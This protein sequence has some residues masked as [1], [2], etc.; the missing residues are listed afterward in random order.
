MMRDNNPLVII[1]WSCDP[2]PYDRI[3]DVIY[4]KRIE[5]DIHGLANAQHFWKY[6]NY[7]Y[8]TTNIS[9]NIKIL[10]P[11]NFIS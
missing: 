6:M 3:K 11:N 8:K 2:K 10:S 9:K 1:Q 7:L 5:K 4:E